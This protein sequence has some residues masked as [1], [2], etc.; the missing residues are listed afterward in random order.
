M[1]WLGE[2]APTE[3]LGPVVIGRSPSAEAVPGAPPER[4]RLVTVSDPERIVSRSHL[5]IEPVGEALRLRNV[6]S[7]NPVKVVGIDGGVALVAGERPF[8]VRTT[9]RAVIGAVI[10]DLIVD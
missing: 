9:S 1:L 5:V 8:E 3:I 7:R 4:T 10:V 2:G 6:S